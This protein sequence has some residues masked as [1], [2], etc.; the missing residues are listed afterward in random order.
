M[1]EEQ[2]T[3]M[4]LDGGPATNTTYANLN[5]MPTEI[6]EIILHH[7][8]IEPLPTTPYIRLGTNY[9]EKK[10]ALLNMSL[11]SKGLHDIAN[12]FLYHNVLIYT[13]E[14]ATL[15]LRTLWNQPNVRQFTQHIAI[16]RPLGGK[17]LASEM[18]R[19]W[20]QKCND[21]FLAPQAIESNKVMKDKAGFPQPNLFLMGDQ[22]LFFQRAFDYNDRLTFSEPRPL[23][24][25]SAILA[26]LEKLD[27]VFLHV[28]Q[29]SSYA[30]GYKVSTSI[31]LFD[32]ALQPLIPSPKT[33]R[34]HPGKNTNIFEEPAAFDPLYLQFLNIGKG[35]KTDDPYK[36]TIKRFECYSDTGNW[37]PLFGEIANFEEIL[38]KLPAL[39][40][41]DIDKFSVLEELRLYKSKT[42]SN[43]IY[44]F[45]MRFANLR[46]LHWTTSDSKVNVE[47]SS[48][49]VVC[50]GLE[51]ALTPAANRL[52]RLHLEPRG[53]GGETLI[54]EPPVSLAHFCV[55]TYL[56]VDINVLLGY[57]HVFWREHH[58]D[59]DSD[60]G[61]N[62][63][64]MMDADDSEH[65]KEPG[66][67]PEL[68][69]LASLLPRSLV[70]LVAIDRA[71][72]LGEHEDTTASRFDFYPTTTVQAYV[73]AQK[74]WELAADCPTTHPHLRTITLQT[75]REGGF[76]ED[77]F[78][79]LIEAYA[80]I[81][82]SLSWEEFQLET[83]ELEDGVIWSGAPEDGHGPIGILPPCEDWMGG[84]IPDFWP[85]S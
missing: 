44:M 71:T 65:K 25:I 53:T 56:A 52:Q 38:G 3:R 17:R 63:D 35:T 64:E 1:A 37:S 34:M 61:S 75:Y 26:L 70:E 82:V 46:T 19:T 20:E 8:K 7:F 23:K 6:M 50:M 43:Y 41:E 10:Q 77:S 76:N 13:G 81:G 27:D 80:R 55:L 60:S 2:E 12:C 32:P 47:N 22:M 36:G 58:P 24:L 4:V 62:D 59:S 18:T 72:Y 45:T 48:S 40:Q 29:H 79:G 68:P 85:W 21:K 5:M 57:C 74:L 28:P 51:D 67:E 11:V 39:G 31:G 54:A 9:T 15:L 83:Q 69:A 42:N 49:F 73:V 16:L 84:H 30:E 66:G 14:Q 78:E 33:L